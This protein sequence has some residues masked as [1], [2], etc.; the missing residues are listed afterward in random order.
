MSELEER[1]RK[2]LA[3]RWKLHRQE[4]LNMAIGMGVRTAEEAIELAERLGAYIRNGKQDAP[5]TS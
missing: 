4:C 5:S 1:E 3:D 2:E